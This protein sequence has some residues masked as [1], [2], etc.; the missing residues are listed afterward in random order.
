MIEIAQIP[1]LAKRARDAHKGEFGRILVIAG[2]AG[3][4]G[5]GCLTAEAC[6]RSGAGLVTLAVP[7]SLW[8]LA[9][10]KLTCV[11]TRGFAETETQSLSADAADAMCACASSMDVVALGPGLSSHPATFALVRRLVATIARPMVIDADGIN[12]LAGHLDVLA[13][14]RAATVLTPHPGEFSRLCSLPVT[15]L[16]AN[17]LTHSV[18]FAA[19]QRLVLAV[20]F[21]PA[22]VT[23]G[24]R[25]FVNTTGNP[26]MATGG[27][28]DVLTG[29]IAALLA[30]KLSPFAAAQLGVYVHGL[31]GDLACQDK[32][33]VGMIASD[34]LEH[35]PMAFK[36]L[37]RSE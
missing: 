8:P 13:N 23:D 5:A 31:A 26:G 17:R 7:Q 33:E 20:K 2:S 25:Y 9:M 16:A 30:L 18:A 29:V 21:A 37:P 15:E 1:A 14:R 11:M 34:I 36:Q 28:G 3:M 4:L 10:V 19:G 32:G 35:L 6:L 27:S 12:A 24:D 22:L